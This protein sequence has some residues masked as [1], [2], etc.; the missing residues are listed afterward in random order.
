MYL[1]PKAFLLQNQDLNDLMIFGPSD[2][3][4]SRHF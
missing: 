3:N 2:S 1:C 4:T